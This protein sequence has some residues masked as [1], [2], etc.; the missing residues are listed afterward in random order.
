MSARIA[1]FAVALAA[2]PAAFAGNSASVSDLAR[3]TGVSERHIRMVAGARTPYPEYRI[4]YDRVERSLK[5]ALGD[6]GYARLLQ[7]DVAS[8]VRLQ[9]GHAATRAVASRVGAPQREV[10]RYEG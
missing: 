5:A 8:A 7:G 2:A 6:A 1:L 4:V 10:L 3:E 9:R